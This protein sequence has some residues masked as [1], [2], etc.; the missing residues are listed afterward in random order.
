[1][2]TKKIIYGEVFNKKFKIKL[3]ENLNFIKFKLLNT[4][5]SFALNMTENDKPPKMIG[6]LKGKFYNQTSNQIL[7]TIKNL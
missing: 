2:K 4:G 6:N 5:I 7:F 1:M 3:D